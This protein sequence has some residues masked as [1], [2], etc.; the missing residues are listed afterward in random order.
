MKTLTWVVALG[1]LSLVLAAGCDKVKDG[2]VTVPGDIFSDGEAGVPDSLVLDRIIGPLLAN[3]VDDVEILATVV[4]G[5]GRGLADVGVFFTSDAGSMEPFATTDSRGVATARLTS[6]ASAADVQARV[7]AAASSDT[8]GL[9]GIQE[10]YVLVSDEPLS[11]EILEARLAVMKEPGRRSGTDQ[12]TGG[13]KLNGLAGGDLIIDEVTVPMLGITV[14]LEADPSVIPA[15]GISE[16]R[17]TATLTETTRRVPLDRQEISF[18]ATAGT[19][20]GRAT[21]DVSGSAVATLRGLTSGAVSDVTVF[22]GNTLTASVSVTFS[23]LTLALESG[24]AAVPANGVSGTEIVA[25]LLNEERNPVGG[26]RIVFS[27]TLGSISSPVVTGADGEARTFLSAGLETGTAEVVA[28]FGSSLTRTLDVDFVTPPQTATLLLSSDASTLPADGA[29]ETVLTARALDANGDP[30][31]DGTLVSFTKESGAGQ[32]VGGAA[33]TRGGIAEA[34]YVAGA[35]PGSVEIMAVSGSAQASLTLS[36]APTTAVGAIALAIAPGSDGDVLADG[37][38]SAVLEALVTDHFGNPVAPG[39]TV[40]FVATLGTISEA[41][42]TDAG[43]RATARLTSARFVTGT[44]RVTASSGGLLQTLDV[45]FVSEGATNVVALAVDNPHIHVTGAGRTETATV[46]FEARDGRGIPV[47]EDHA[48]LLTFSILPVEGLTDAVVVPSSATTNSKGQ[49]LATVNSGTISGPIEVF[50]ASDAADSEPI[51]I[52]VHA[53]QPDPEHFSISFERIN[54]EGLVYDGVRNAVTARIGDHHGNPVPDSTVAWFHAEYGLIQGSAATDDHGEA[55]VW[56]ITA[57]PRPAIPGGDGLVT[58]CAQTVSK[59]GDLIE[60]CGRVMWSGHTIVEITDP[61]GGFQVPNGGSVTI[62]YR[63]RDA[64]FN[65]LT[66]G[67]EI[68]VTATGGTLGGDV[69]FVLPDTQSQAKTTFSVVLADDDPE[70][71]IT[72]TVTVTVSVESR[73]GNATASITGTVN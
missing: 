29:S 65:P 41:T 40:G 44:S 3:G 60:T 13:R 64:N 54:I 73:N 56:E 11:D 33:L 70:Q 46:T 53:D 30:M 25:R 2:D 5:R 26:A 42:P 16:S 4:D 7:T 72:A 34:V 15:D 55:T 9:L 49:A 35:A 21:T 32:I 66:Q 27:T 20:S 58:L 59:D 23:A 14:R 38:D 57:A 37:A 48:V 22:Y 51:R 12:S 50:A 62:T 52:A 47:D 63:V 68:S 71:D 61:V 36:L 67:T 39:T 6:A 19:I 45:R 24:A 1:A 43:G 17:V 8:L 28:S 18:G 69:G 10:A 31:L